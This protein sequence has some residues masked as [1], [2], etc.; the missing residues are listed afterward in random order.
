MQSRRVFC[1]IEGNKAKISLVVK[2]EV[3]ISIEILEKMRPLLKEF[4]RVMHDELLK[5]LPPHKR[6]PTSYSESN[7]T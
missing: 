5:G 4:K 2:E 7:S 6:Y 3:I 1:G